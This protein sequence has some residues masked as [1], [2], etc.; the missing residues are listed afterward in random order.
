MAINQQ[1]DVLI[2]HTP[3][4]GDLEIKIGVITMGSG[5]R[6]AVY[7]SLFGGNEDDSGGD[8]DP[9]NWWG[10]IGQRVQVRSET[11]FLLQT[12]TPTSAN[13]LRLE[14]AVRRDLNWF[15]A[16]GV[17]TD[18]KARVIIPA[19]NSVKIIINIDNR[20]FEFVDNWSVNA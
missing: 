19:Y 2:F 9:H 13:L 12:M 18:I 10:N 14:D 11:Q 8:R 7:I 4:D 5:L 20:D 15:K 16:S 6:S 1:G 17:A 3:D